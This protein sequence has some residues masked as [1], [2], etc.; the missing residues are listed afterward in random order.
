MDSQCQRSCLATLSMIFSLSTGNTTSTT[1]LFL[2]TFFLK[3]SIY[4]CTVIWSYQSPKTKVNTLY[5]YHII[6][7]IYV[8]TCSTFPKI[9]T[10]VIASF[11]LSSQW[12]VGLGR[13]ANNF[14]LD[15]V[16]FVNW[17]QCQ[18]VCFPM[19]SGATCFDMFPNQE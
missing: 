1:H 18:E 11:K 19:T 16:A 3:P 2:I 13:T 10:M 14:I 12:V 9:P 6:I 15:L 17:S 7:Y 4:T 5:I 8:Y